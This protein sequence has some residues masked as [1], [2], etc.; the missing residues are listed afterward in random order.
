MGPI[1]EKL[2]QLFAPK[3]SYFFDAA[4]LQ[5]FALGSERQ[6]DFEEMPLNFLAS[7]KASSKIFQ[8]V[9]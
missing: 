2:G 7:S 6:L 3:A 9:T 8:K 5:R 4:V 1:Q